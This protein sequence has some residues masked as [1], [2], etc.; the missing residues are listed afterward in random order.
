MSSAS[1]QSAARAYR[2]LS[3]PPWRARFHLKWPR[4]GC[5]LCEVNA[6]CSHWHFGVRRPKTGTS[7]IRRSQL[8]NNR[9]VST[10][11]SRC[12]PVFVLC[13]VRLHVM[14]RWDVH[15]HTPLL[16]MLL[17]RVSASDKAMPRGQV[18][19]TL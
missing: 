8:R 3:A 14:S 1:A 4:R 17:F 5:H 6:A 10:R 2:M 19:Y 18:L 15:D 11:R 16:C 9:G 7:V 12:A 13:W